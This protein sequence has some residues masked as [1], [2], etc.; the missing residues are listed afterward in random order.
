MRVQMMMEQS[1]F[2]NELTDID[3]SLA[4]KTST[5]PSQNVAPQVEE[6]FSVK[7]IIQQ[8]NGGPTPWANSAKRC[9]FY[10]WASTTLSTFHPWPSSSRSRHPSGRYSHSGGPVGGFGLLRARSTT[11]GGK[12]YLIHFLEALI[13][14][15]DFR[16]T[17]YKLLA[18][19]L[20]ID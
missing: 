5:F 6:A 16:G 18:F 7:E 11:T 4:E 14:S 12:Q 10:R 1:I 9:H 17:G 2:T 19:R 15:G 8:V 20:S 13:M 3:M